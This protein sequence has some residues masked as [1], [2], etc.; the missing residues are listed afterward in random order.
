MLRSHSHPSAFPMIEVTA[1]LGTVELGVHLLTSSVP[2]AVTAAIAAA[3]SPAEVLHLSLKLYYY[4]GSCAQNCQPECHLLWS[5]L[6]S[7]LLHLL[8]FRLNKGRHSNQQVIL[9]LH[10]ARSNRSAAAGNSERI[11]GRKGALGE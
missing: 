8:E 7:P 4:F 9:Q 2:A 1:K 6:C 11:G 3:A 5:R 10:S